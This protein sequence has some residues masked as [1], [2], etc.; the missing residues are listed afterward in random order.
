MTPSGLSVREGFFILRKRPVTRV[1][2]AEDLHIDGKDKVAE[3]LPHDGELVGPKGRDR[4]VAA[5]FCFWH[6]HA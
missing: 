4:Y 1:V 3:V 5:R 2:A 6:R